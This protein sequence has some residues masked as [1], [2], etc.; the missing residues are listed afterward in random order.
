VLRFAGYT[1]NAVARRY[2]DASGFVVALTRA[3][4]TLLLARDSARRRRAT[5]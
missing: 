3:E 2:R 1:L 4:L 5:T